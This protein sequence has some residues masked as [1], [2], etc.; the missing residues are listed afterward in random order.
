[1]FV[2]KRD[3]Y[4]AFLLRSPT[5]R[6]PRGSPTYSRALAPLAKGAGG[7]LFC[8]RCRRRQDAIGERSLAYKVVFLKGDESVGTTAWA[9]RDRAIVFARQTLRLRQR[10]LGATAVYVVDI[11]TREVIFVLAAEGRDGWVI[12]PKSD[13]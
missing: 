1:V 4:V 11:R 8:R 13:A 2:L 7:V 5:L 3:D 6:G 9:D 10:D 12:S